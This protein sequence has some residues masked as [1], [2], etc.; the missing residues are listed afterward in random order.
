MTT[1]SIFHQN[2]PEQAQTVVTDP[3]TIRNKLSAHGV[4]FDR[5]ATRD[6]PADATQEEI[7]EA[8]ADEMRPW[9]H[10]RSIEAVEHLARWRGG[11]LGVNAAEAFCLM[12][13]LV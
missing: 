12:R 9:P 3:D 1:L 8:Y 11:Q 10:S 7:L 6:L 5:W 4:H 2:Q 13:A